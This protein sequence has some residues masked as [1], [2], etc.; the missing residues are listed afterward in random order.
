MWDFL[1]EGALE[2]NAYAYLDSTRSSNGNVANG[3]GTPGMTL[4]QPEDSPV[5]RSEGTAAAQG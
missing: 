1:P 4:P 3:A 2:H 5:V